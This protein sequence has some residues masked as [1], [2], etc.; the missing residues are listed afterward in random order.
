MHIAVHTHG[1]RGLQRRSSG[2]RQRIRVLSWAFTDL[3]V[4]FS[5]LTIECTNLNFFQTL[6]FT[7]DLH[8]TDAAFG[9]YEP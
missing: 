8:P 9:K 5:R 6:R 3:H 2:I 1:L 7:N 4:Q